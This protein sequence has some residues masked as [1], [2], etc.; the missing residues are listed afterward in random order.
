MPYYYTPL[1]EGTP[2]FV[3][4]EYGETI[5][6]EPTR[7]PGTDDGSGGVTFLGG[8]GTAMPTGISLCHYDDTLSRVVVGIDHEVTIDGWSE[9]TAAQ[10]ETDYPGVI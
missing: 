5:T 7:E 3:D 4:P 2:S 6:G 10:V 9:Q 8:T 1:Y